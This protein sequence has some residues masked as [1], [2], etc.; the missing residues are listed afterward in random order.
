MATSGYTERATAAI[1]EAVRH[2]GGF[3][4]RLAQVLS[5]A[6]AQLASSDALTAGRPG[7]READ[8]MQQP[9]KGTVGWN[10]EYLDGYRPAP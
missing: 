5:G 2:E 4:G 8:L 10:D 6:G 3:G 7:S 9:V 1:V